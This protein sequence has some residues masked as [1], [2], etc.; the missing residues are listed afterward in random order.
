MSNRF[1]EFRTLDKDLSR[2]SAAEHAGQ[3]AAR[4]VMRLGLAALF[5]AAMTLVAL[6]MVAGQTG[7][8]MVAA[9]GAVAAYL[10]MSIGANDVANSMGP[11]VGA[12]AI[13]ARRALVLAALAEIA[14]AWFAGGP[15]A[16]RLSSGIITA[17]AMA[18]LPAAQV[19][20]AALMAAG[21]WINLATW[22][23]APVSTTHS[24]VGAIAGAG[25]A[26]SGITAVHWPVA[27]LIA[28]SW[29]ISPLVAAAI[30]AALLAFVRARIHAAPDR[31]RAAVLWLPLLLG[32]MAAVFAGYLVIVALHLPAPALAL[33][34]L[35]AVAVW[36]WARRRLRREI[37]PEHSQKEALQALFALPL[38][39][40]AVL[41][42]FAHG[43][44][45]VAN[46]AAP[47][48]II[49]QESTLRAQAPDWIILLAAAGIALGVLLFGGRLVRMVGS[50]ITRLNPVRAFCVT[51]ATAVT[52][53]SASA[54]GLP[55]STTYVAVGG[56][57]GVGFFREW[58]DRRQRKA[59]AAL[60]LEERQ[61]RHLVRRSHVA[62]VIAAWMVTVPVCAALSAAVFTALAGLG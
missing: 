19:M 11:A 48:Q 2:L 10:A 50:G 47:L 18:L 30:A 40:G 56:V 58:D 25:L 32:L 27:A 53:L 22:A 5:I 15:V 14:G 23:G 17:E 41:V 12:G 24:V 49:V 43:A 60:P 52:V 29:M 6:G 4:P 28:A 35:A 62:T 54:A 33:A 46:I 26:A 37:R 20:L 31:I 42:S 34:P 51:V 45:D 55:V 59:R 21:L 38:A 13:T 61:R 16:A 7:L 57:F 39:M 36:L 9:G 44:N 1:P 8:A 3:V